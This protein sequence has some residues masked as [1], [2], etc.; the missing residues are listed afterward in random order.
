MDVPDKVELDCDLARILGYYA[1]EGWC[2][3]HGGIGPSRV[4]FSM[5]C[6]EAAKERIEDLQKVLAD[7]FGVQMGCCSQTE[8]KVQITVADRRVAML[9]AELC[10]LAP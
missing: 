3:D 6:P 4:V 1:A 10:V 9:F 8:K 2:S 5:G 7:K